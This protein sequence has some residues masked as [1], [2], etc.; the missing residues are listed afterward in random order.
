MTRVAAALLA[1]LALSACD[2]EESVPSS[3]GVVA[4]SPVPSCEEMAEIIRDEC[5]IVWA[6]GDRGSC[7]RGSDCYELAVACR[8]DQEPSSLDLCEPGS[9]CAQDFADAQ[10]DWRAA[11]TPECLAGTS[12]CLS[13]PE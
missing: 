7:E 13:C 10:A 4:E 9:E 1:L 8:A 11:T 6:G 2:G 3:N 5:T 12:D